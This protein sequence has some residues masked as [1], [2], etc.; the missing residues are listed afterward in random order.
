MLELPGYSESKRQRK[1]WLQRMTALGLALL[2]TVA[3][4]WLTQEF[5][6]ALLLSLLAAVAAGIFWLII[7]LGHVQAQRDRTLAWSKEIGWRMANFF[8]DQIER[9]DR[10]TAQRLKEL[11]SEIEALRER[12]RLLQVQAYHDDLTG[13]ANR[14]L[15]TDHFLSAVE[16]SKRSGSPF[17]LL[18]VDLNDFKEINDRHGHGVGDFVLITTASRLLGAL[19][20]SDTVARLGGDEFVLIV[21]SIDNDQEFAQVGQKL[22]E[23][24]FEPV[25]LE[26]GKRIEVGASLGMALYPNDGLKMSDLLTV[27]D[28]AMYEC[29][30]T[31]LISLF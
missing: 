8:Q 27:A 19:R 23:S 5:A 15:L 14:A 30:S 29:K 31:G 10:E 17:A 28:Q 6:S 9:T 16:R 21:E 4:A 2:G 13:L 26:N 22:I 7:Q 1:N 3:Y 20:A 11:Q 24:L 18:M 12:E 25:S